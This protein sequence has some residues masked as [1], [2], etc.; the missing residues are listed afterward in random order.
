M[1]W[2]RNNAKQAV[3]PPK[4]DGAVGDE[5]L[6]QPN[7]DDNDSEID[8]ATNDEGMNFEKFIFFF[9]ANKKNKN[10]I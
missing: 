5:L 3:E 8:E 7:S 2:L 4:S 1:D 10:H 9:I 6:N